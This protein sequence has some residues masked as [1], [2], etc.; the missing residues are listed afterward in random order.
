MPYCTRGIS[1]LLYYN[2][3]QLSLTPYFLNQEWDGC[4]WWHP[5]PS[6]TQKELTKEVNLILWRE[7]QRKWW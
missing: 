2:R 5:L 1:S 6:A 4:L 3:Q 7:A